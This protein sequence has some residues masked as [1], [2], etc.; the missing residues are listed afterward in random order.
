MKA[1]AGGE[2]M[3]ESTGP[4]PLSLAEQRV[5]GVLIEK[6]KTTPDVY[7]MS[8]NG[9]TV[10]CN[11]KSNRDPV[12][13][14]ADE[15]VEATLEGLH[16]KQLVVRVSGGR[17]DKWKHVLYEVWNIDKVEMAVL[18]ELFLRGPQTEGELRTRVGR[19]EPVVDLDALRAILH[20]LCER[21][22]TVY[23]TP[24]GRRGTIA[25]HGCLEPEALATLKSRYAEGIR[26]DQ[27]SMAPPHS[28]PSASAEEIAELRK[29][30]ADLRLIV[31][32]LAAQVQQ[33]Q[34][35]LGVLPPN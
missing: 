32:T 27:S 16:Q 19:M 18:A 22:F 35:Q 34:Q 30:L 26:L 4:I 11:Q 23:L 29:E 7:P 12:L 31:N 14:L 1:Y 6:Q 28:A 9:L 10:G 13:H 17:V 24:E 2:N 20:R 33:L 25:G 5:L 8:V 21:G 3:G 15:E